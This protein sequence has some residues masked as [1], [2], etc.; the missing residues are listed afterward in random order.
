MPTPD[1][2]TLC[3]LL[4]ALSLIENVPVSVPGVVGRKFREYAQLDLG[5]RLLPFAQVVPVMEIEK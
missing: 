5:V 3:G 1:R 2:L 4:R